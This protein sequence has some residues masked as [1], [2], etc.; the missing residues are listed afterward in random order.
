LWFTFAG[1]LTSCFS[2]CPS[3]KSTNTV[4]APRPSIVTTTSGA[5]AEASSAFTRQ[6]PRS[7]ARM[8][9]RARATPSHGA[10]GVATTSYA[11]SAANWWRRLS[12]R[13][14]VRRSLCPSPKSIV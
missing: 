3:P 6:M 9:M 8:S 12:G 5:V 2:D 1:S 10:S 13:S 11:L 14:A 7:I 4:H